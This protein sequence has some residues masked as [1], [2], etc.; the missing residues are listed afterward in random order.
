MAK[1]KKSVFGTLLKLGGLAAAGAAI[2]YK[3]DEIKAFL[4]DAAERIFPEDEETLTPEDIL[5]V[6]P[7]I[8]INAA[9]NAEEAAQTEEDAPEA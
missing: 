8:V 4:T 6:E 2:Y 3:R 9:A 1:K 7:D 5:D